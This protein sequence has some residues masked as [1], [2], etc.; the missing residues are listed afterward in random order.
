MAEKTSTPLP[1]AEASIANPCELVGL[2]FDRA[3]AMG[4]SDA[5]LHCFALVFLVLTRWC[6]LAFVLSLVLIFT[7]CSFSPS[8]V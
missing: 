1:H 7:G 5:D 3:L 8:P 4:C 2:E 6:R